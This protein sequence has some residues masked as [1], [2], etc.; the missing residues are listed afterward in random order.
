MN[1]ASVLLAD[2]SPAV[3]DCVTKL[4]AKD[5]EVVAAVKSGAPVL[6]AWPQFRPD[7][8]VLD[9]SMGEPTGIEVARQLRDAGCDS[10]IVFLTVHDDPDFLKA[11]MGAGG[12]GYV[13]KS[14]MSS[15]L[16]PAIRAVL[17]G[18]LFIS[19]SLLYEGH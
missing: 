15:D 4:L 11:A 12:S 2:N 1:K 19:E 14:R 3:L 17:S 10:K 8:M 5:Y 7:V 6:T 18:K 9:I 16:L 13:V